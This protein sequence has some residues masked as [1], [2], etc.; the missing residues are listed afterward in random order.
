MD[1]D[2]SQVERD[3]FRSE[4]QR[5]E[6]QVQ[7]QEQEHEQEHEQEQRGEHNRDN[8]SLGLSHDQSK[9]ATTDNEHPSKSGNTTALSLIT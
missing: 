4:L 1:D 3:S 2:R 6:L 8:Q 9:G 7:S 5:S